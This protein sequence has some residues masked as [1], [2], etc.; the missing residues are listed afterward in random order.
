MASFLSTLYLAALN[1]S[2]SIS[3]RGTDMI[4]SK[5]RHDHS[6][7]VELSHPPYLPIFSHTLFTFDLNR[8]FSLH[9]HSSGSCAVDN[10]RTLEY[11]P[12]SIL[13]EAPRQHARLST[14]VTRTS[15]PTER[16]SDLLHGPFHSPVPQGFFNRKSRFPSIS[17]AFWMEYACLSIIPSLVSERFP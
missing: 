10:G 5:T 7:T 8:S 6:R 4:Q 9:Y 3:S 14:A 2:N 1:T 11:C 15:D 17:T 16:T 12:S 13:F